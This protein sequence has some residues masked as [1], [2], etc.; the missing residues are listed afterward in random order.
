M[1][2]M[3]SFYKR[4]LEKS[5]QEFAAAGMSRVEIQSSLK[6]K[7]MLPNMHLDATRLLSRQEG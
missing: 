7:V 3:K 4:L 6:N 2:E 5:P 1:D